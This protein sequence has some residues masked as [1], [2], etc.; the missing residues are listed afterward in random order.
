MSE[1]H[2]RRSKG[3][4]GAGRLAQNLKVLQI[5]SGRLGLVKN[6]EGDSHVGDAIAFEHLISL[7]SI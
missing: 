3:L 7:H 2:E 4:P 1:L 6:A 5:G